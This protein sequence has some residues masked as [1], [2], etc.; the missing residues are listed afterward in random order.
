VRRL[1]IS[2][3]LL[4]PCFWQSRIQAGDL[5]SHVYNAWLAGIVEREKLPGL[6]VAWRWHNILFDLLLG[7]LAAWI[8]SAAAQRIAVSLVVL[9]FFWGA[10]RF[11]QR[12]AGTCPWPVQLMLALFSYGYVFHHGFFNYYLS[13]GIC[14]WILS[15]PR[16]GDRAEAW[17]AAALAPLAALAHLIPVFCAAGLLVYDLAARRLNLRGRF[18]LFGGVVASLAAIRIYLS[19]TRE[20]IMPASGVMFAGA[21]QLLLFSAPYA[22]ATSVLLVV[23]ILLFVLLWEQEGWRGILE[24]RAAGLWAVTIAALVLLPRGFD[25]PNFRH[26]IVYL[27]DRLSLLTAV[28]FCALLARLRFPKPVGPIL[29]AVAAWYGWLIYAD[30]AELNR[31]EDRIREAVVKLAP[32]SRVIAYFGNSGRRLEPRLHLLDRACAGHCFNYAN[33]E[34]STWQFRV[35]AV[36]DNP[37]ALAGFKDVAELEGKGRYR[38]RAQDLPLW[39]L[40]DASRPGE[41]VLGQLE[42]GDLVA[43]AA[44]RLRAASAPVGNSP[45][46]VR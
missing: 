33:Y 29:V 1:A 6:E 5:A 19:A 2:A 23:W 11:V 8:G 25:L 10:V 39:L 22:I 35:R 27:T 21:D 17:A 4:I 37:A 34:P 9:V 16:D 20:T 45:P 13:L 40:T 26:G 32:R 3:A 14:F 30:A 28:C 24:S 18:A 36:A 7:G 43:E 42:A 41:F 12:A 44:A 38:V 46:L 15:L 31:Q